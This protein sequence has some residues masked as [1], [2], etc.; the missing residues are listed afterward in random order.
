MR[1]CEN[2]CVCVHIHMCDMPWDH[3]RCQ[4]PLSTLF[5]Q[6]LLLSWPMSFQGV[7]GLCLPS[8]CRRH[9]LPHP[10]F[11]GFFTLA[12]LY[13]VNHFPKH[14]PV[15]PQAHMRLHM[16]FTKGLSGS[17]EKPV[18]SRHFHR[19]I[20]TP[21]TQPCPLPAEGGSPCHRHSRKLLS[22]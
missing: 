10:A 17:M 18:A 15:F 6:G 3:L 7:S 21:A 13:S 5:T 22:Q 9:M 8:C 16:A 20:I 1:V 2:V 19:P 11:H 4:S 14:L 12:W